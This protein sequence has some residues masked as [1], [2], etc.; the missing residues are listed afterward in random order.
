MEPTKSFRIPFADGIPDSR[1]HTIDHYYRSVE[2][3]KTGNLVESKYKPDW[4]AQLFEMGYKKENHFK[5]SFFLQNHIS[6]PFGKNGSELKNDYRFIFIEPI[7]GVFCYN[8]PL[9]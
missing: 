8:E 7:K 5:Y 6:N 2:F 4:E 3:V 9:T 1:L